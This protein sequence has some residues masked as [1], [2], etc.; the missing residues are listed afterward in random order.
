MVNPV[1]GDFVY[2][3]PLM[4]VPGPEG[5]YPLSLSYHA[6]INPEQESSW[7]GLGWTLNPG[8]I[9]R[10][11][12]G[13]PDDWANTQASRRDYWS[14]GVTNV[15][16]V[17]VTIPVVNVSADVIV[18]KDTYR[19][20][21][22]GW[23][24]AYGFSLGEDSGVRATIGIGSNPYSSGF[25][26]IGGLSAMGLS[27]TGSLGENNSLGISTSLLSVYG[28]SLLDANLSTSG[29]GVSTNISIESSLSNSKEG[30]V[31]TETKKSGLNLLFVRFSKIRTRYWSD[32]TE[33][34]NIY[35]ALN[36]K[37]FSGL[38]S[39]NSLVND[40]FQLGSGSDPDKTQD[41]AQPAFDSYMVTGQGIGGYMRPFIYQGS[42][43]RQNVVERD[44]SSSKMTVQY[45]NNTKVSNNLGFR[46][47]GDFSN[48]LQQNYTAFSTDPNTILNGTLPFAA[49]SGN[50]GSWS[51][52]YNSTNQV[53]AGSKTIQYFKTDANGNVVTPNTNVKF[54]QPVASG[55]DRK[56]HLGPIASGTTNSGI[57]GFSI[58]NESGVTY[59]Y[60]LPAYSYEEEVYQENTVKLNS[61][62]LKFNRQTKN[63][64]YAYT[65]HLTAVTGPDYVDRGTIG[66]LDEA[67]YGYWVSFEYGK[68]TDEFV[69][70]T[71]TE[72]FTNNID[73]RFKT[74]SMGKKEV[75]YLNAIKTRTH[76][77]LF[78][79]DVRTDGKSAS[80][81][82]F[83]KNWS[84][85]NSVSTDY[86]NAGLYN[87]NSNQSL[88]LSHV[89]I[90]KNTGIPSVGNSS[91]G[92]SGFIPSGRTVSCTEC[93]LSN[94]VFDKNDVN[95]Y[96]RSQLESSS[97]RVI[98]FDYDYSLAKG[99]TTS[100]DYSSPSNKLGKLTLKSFKIRGKGGASILPQT[101]FGYNLSVSDQKKGLATVSPG[102]I[103]GTT[104][105]YELGDL[106]ETDDADPVFCGYIDQI[107]Q[108]GS[109][110]SYVLKGGNVTS[111]LGSKNI[112]KTKNPPYE[113][114]K[115]DYWGMYKSD[116]V[117]Y[118]N[119]NLSRI[120]TRIS[121]KSTDV[122]SL[123]TIKTS[124]GPLVEIGFEGHDFR[125]SIYGN[126]ISV[127]FISVTKLSP[128][129]YRLTMI[130]NGRACKDI[131]QVGENILAV[132]FREYYEKNPDP[133]MGGRSVDP[134]DPNSTKM[135]DAYMGSTVLV[136]AMNGNTMDVEFADYLEDNLFNVYYTN[137]SQ[138]KV[139]D[140]N[141][142]ATAMDKN[143]LGG[144][145]VRVKSITLRSLDGIKYTTNY[146][147][148]KDD[149][150]V[151]S[152]VTSYEPLNYERYQGRASTE[153]HY[154]SIFDGTLNLGFANVSY[155]GPELPGPGVMYSRVES[156]SKIVYPDGA[157]GAPLTKNVMEFFT[158]Q[159]AKIEKN[160]VTSPSSSTSY[161][162]ANHLFRKFMSLMGSP[163]TVSYYDGNGKLTKRVVNQY[164]HEGITG[165]F[166]AGYKTKLQ[167]FGYQGLLSERFS[168]VK[169]VLN[170]SN[171][172]WQTMGT[173]FAREDYPLVNVGTV[174]YDYIHN[175]KTSKKVNAFDFYS[176][177][178]TESISTDSYG[179]SFLSQ[180]TPAYRDFA[181]MGPSQLDGTKKHMLTQVS[182]SNVY[183][184]NASGAKEHL[185]SASYNVW[186]NGGAV[187]DGSGNRIVQNNAATNGNVWRQTSGYVWMPL[188]VAANGMTAVASFVAFPGSNPAGANA[189]W[190]RNNDVV[191]MDAYSHVL[192][193]R[194]FKNNHTSTR[195]GYNNAKPVLSGTF[196]KYGEIVFS[197]AEDENISNGKKLEVSKG[198]G[199]VSTAVFH[200][201]SKS[202]QLA[203]D[204]TGFD[205]SVPV[206]ELTAGRTYTASVWVNNQTAHNVK[207]YY[208]LDGVDKT[209]SGASNVSTRTSGKWTLITFDI[210]LSGGTTVRVFAKNDGTGTTY[211]DDFRFQPKNGVSSASVYNA[212]TGEL[213]YSLDR[214]NLYTRYEYNA[215]GQ[216]IAT[217]REQFG[218]T[219]YKVSETQL[220]YSTRSFNGLS[221]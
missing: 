101:E 144:N 23:N 5:S 48:T 27:L 181:A 188:S 114:D 116:Y 127:H 152:G 179:N 137:R 208:Q 54:I 135:Y 46:F 194:D 84:S 104:V 212:A 140:V 29:V 44:A 205:Y 63:A 9:T 162:T 121:N 99:A 128:L 158:F 163:K 17:G 98:D 45:G 103:S 66:V 41:G 139:L 154:E 132:F 196:A 156:V 160:Y 70:R 39:D 115:Y 171:N 193:T 50:S 151:S 12:S 81:E 120:P 15:T 73:Q 1:T 33:N 150:S 58:T 190:K 16:S 68:W 19:G 91:G 65:W 72:G 111:N 164:L 131:Y 198:T 220:N 36:S 178:V 71:P 30:V 183:R 56:K 88:R 176:G 148:C 64:G 107:T 31:Q 145:G 57:T 191:L 153:G 113:K 213:S 168:E 13:F 204:Q 207:L 215:M 74:V 130:N 147:Y 175:T 52:G 189:A 136:K 126:N 53:L 123:R 55:L 60:N 146:K 138:T 22:I 4:E 79:K 129:N 32:E 8:S 37:S 26:V 174:E 206:S 159:D 169:K 210:T 142:R 219:P 180:S 89:Y 21:G 95:A 182:A 62:D 47:L 134:I 203:A 112:R 28:Y 143:H 42:V 216:L 2:N 102:S 165:D 173:M 125:E 109:T 187:L 166:F 97:L 200:T 75:Y 177:A 86:S 77:A 209:V 192:S 90:L 201:G 211:V 14:G 117:S 141:L 76:T 11:I 51:S 82:S 35:G 195:Y 20:V 106:I 40:A 6:G 217:Y 25:S 170:T 18:V 157:N 118:F 133:N 69:W 67:D 167:G 24:V 197:G 94:N 105:A 61:S 185:V 38:L 87:A 34:S 96:G 100:F 186:S 3:V 43:S 214:N 149:S 93:E 119:Q 122:W 199:T 80:K 92:S 78:E 202:L 7:V 85:Q 172:T 108:S 59:H 83:N 10:T 184:L 221:N 110:Y 218:R 124:S 155:Y 161:A 49:P